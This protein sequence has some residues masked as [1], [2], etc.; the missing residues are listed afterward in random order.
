MIGRRKFLSFIGLGALAPVAAKAAAALPETKL[1]RRVV[2][3]LPT[4]RGMTSMHRIEL[5]REY[6][7]G[8]LFNPYIQSL[9]DDEVA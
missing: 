6:I 7:R 5:T 9:T 4:P 8:G 1:V 2:E 3:V